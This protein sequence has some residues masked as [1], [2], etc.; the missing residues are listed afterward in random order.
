MYFLRIGDNE[1]VILEVTKL[2]EDIGLFIEPI[3]RGSPE[4]AP[5]KGGYI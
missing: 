3:F 5:G 1:K 2:R 4:G